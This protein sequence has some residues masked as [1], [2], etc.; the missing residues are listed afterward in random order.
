[1]PS[2]LF[3]CTANRF[4]S[5]LAA[6][7]FQRMLG[8]SARTSPWSVDSAGTWTSTGLQVLPEALLIA[9]RQGFDLSGH[10]SKLVSEALLSTQDLILVMESGQR[11]ALQNEFPLIID[12]I[13]LLSH[14]TEG[15]F[16]DIPDPID[17]ME[18]MMEVGENIHELVK[19]GFGNIYVLAIHLHATR[20]N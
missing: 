11:E 4:R 8:S 9:R 13:Y 20:Q 5:P 12:R 1:M 2:V 18:A 16:Y 10:R 14:V 17:S 3:V 15:R 19:T 7:F 6:A